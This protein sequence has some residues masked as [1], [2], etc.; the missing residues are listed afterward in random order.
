MKQNTNKTAGN[1]QEL[2][3]FINRWKISRV[4][5]AEQICMNYATFKQKLNENN[6]LHNFSDEEYEEVITAIAEQA[7]S[8]S[9][10]VKVSKMAKKLSKSSSKSKIFIPKKQVAPF[11][12]SHQFKTLDEP[13]QIR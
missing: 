3:A 4:V 11:I 1:R 8:F 13:Q 9:A 5:L 12:L 10:F 2:V 7:E 6:H